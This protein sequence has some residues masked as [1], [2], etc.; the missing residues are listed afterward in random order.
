M[1]NMKL[2]QFSWLELCHGAM[3]KQGSECGMFDTYGI[4]LIASYAL[5]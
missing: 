4:D 5:T 2:F 3:L 1:K